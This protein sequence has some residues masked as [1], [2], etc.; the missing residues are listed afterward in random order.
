MAP[1][2]SYLTENLKM[3]RS[4]MQMAETRTVTCKRC[5]GN[6]AWRQSKRTGKWYLAETWV[7]SSCK[8]NK[9]MVTNGQ[10]HK[11]RGQVQSNAP[12]SGN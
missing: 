7:D 11:C 9:V 3:A 4:G 6:A 5:G 2:T 8:E 12:F 10:P 1:F